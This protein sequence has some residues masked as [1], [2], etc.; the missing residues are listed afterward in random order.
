MDLPGGPLTQ[1]D[2]DALARSAIDQSIVEL[3]RLR[4]VDSVE[5]GQ[6]V[7]RNGGANYAGIVFPYIRPGDKYVREYRLRR[8]KPEMEQAE[9]GSFRERNKYLSPPGRGNMLYFLPDTPPEWLSDPSMPI[10]ITEGE[11][12]ALALW[13]LAYHRLGDAAER[14]RWM[15]VGIAGVWNWKGTVGKTEGPNGDRRDIKGPIPDL[16]HIDWSGRE[17][18]IIF[19]CNVHFNESV[20]VARSKLA[21]ELRKRGARVLFVDIP[22]DAGVNG[23][24]DLTG[25]RGKDSVLEL[26]KTSAYDP[27]RK[28]HSR[29]PSKVRIPEIPSVHSFDLNGIEFVVAGLVAESAVTAITGDAGIGKT[30]LATALAGSVSRGVDFMGRRCTQ[31]SVLILD[32]E[33]TAPIVQERLQRL[34]IQDGSALKIWGSW[35]EE[36]A[37]EP[38]AVCILEWVQACQPKP[39]LI[40]DSLIAFLNG[41]END[42]NTVRT[43][44]QQLRRLADMGAAVIVLH[45][46]GKGETSRKYRGSSD[47]KASID[48][49]YNVTNFGG[50]QLQRLRLE[51]FKTRFAVETDLVVSYVDGQ[52]P[53]DDR[54]NAVVRTVNEQLQELLRQ[55]PGIKTAE[56][57]K[58][59][60]ELKLGWGRARQY[61]L[62]L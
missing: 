46:S 6:L 45:H 2:V 17:V 8:D 59:A 48:V 55:N 36:P 11:K 61:P 39:L 26:L 58:R 22:Q 42:A 60:G 3:A 49:G 14:P 1:E 51:A 50:N 15:P 37:P 31:R 47:F 5:G 30:T 16:D 62:A 44:M 18:T 52:F 33:N 20:Q 29:Q 28:T 25:L 54:P 9:G 53:C 10:V 7:G 12:K 40:V 41:D 56:F 35:L 38:G 23:I 21:G 13:G 34:R 43:F 57:E 32:R 19:D 27:Q 4:R 24:D